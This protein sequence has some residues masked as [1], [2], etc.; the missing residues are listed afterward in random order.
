MNKKK[1][2][3]KLKQANLATKNDIADFR[4]KKDFDQKLNV[5]S[6]KQET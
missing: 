1:N 4:K 2:S 5:T 3:E 6:N